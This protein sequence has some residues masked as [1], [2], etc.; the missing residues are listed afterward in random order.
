MG[1]SGDFVLARS[2][3][4]LLE[5]A[6]FGA[7]D[8]C[9]A[10]GGA[11]VHRC[12]ARPGGWQTVQ[13]GHELL[14]ESRRRWLRELVAQTGA[15]ALVA[16]V[17]DSDVCQVWGESPSGASWTV[18]LDP[19]MAAD[20]DIP[21]PGP[22]QVREAAGRIVAWAA[23]AGFAADRDALLGV[24]SRRADPFVEDLFFALIDACGLPPADP[25]LTAAGPDAPDSPAH[26]GHRP[27][28]RSPRGLGI[29]AAVRALP[30]DGHLVMECAG[31]EQCYAQVWYRPDRTYQVEYRD[32][33]PAEHYWTRTLSVEK[34]VAALTGWAAG[35]VAWR[36]SFDWT[37]LA[38]WFT[39]EPTA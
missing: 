26:P 21:I 23:E 39:E 7:D 10:C 20:Y 4:P 1:F 12:D 8:V 22:E 16:L 13:F 36:E 14:T 33:S 28:G 19:V 35:E 17:F 38:P 2:E 5:L 29:G 6:A 25:A 31:D 30:P 32:C 9:G 11:C 27:D 37:P 18:F 3:R 24:L 15:P 34:V